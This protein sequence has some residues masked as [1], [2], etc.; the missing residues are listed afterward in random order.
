[1]TKTT[2]KNV[3]LEELLLA[4]QNSKNLSEMDLSHSTLE[5]FSAFSSPILLLQSLQI[6]KLCAS[7]PQDFSLA[8]LMKNELLMSSLHVLDLSGNNWPVSDLIQM[9]DLTKRL[10]ELSLSGLSLSQ[11]D[12]KDLAGVLSK[13]HYLSVIRFNCFKMTAVDH[14]FVHFITKQNI[15]T[16]ELCN[17]ICDDSNVYYEICSSVKDATSLHSLDLSHNV[18]INNATRTLSWSIKQCLK[19][20]MLRLCDC[21]IRKNEAEELAAAIIAC[22]NI[23]S[24]DMSQNGFD[25]VHIESLS[26][27]FAH[28]D[29]LITFQV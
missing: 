6:L 23:K 11:N 10:Q 15:T 22:E 4:F 7:K 17:L 18:G 21:G 26:S 2:F 19:L 27:K 14:C 29:H 5:G 3:S 8:S 28:C 25:D 24:I 20:N 13:L 1:M 12:T 16:L 9:F